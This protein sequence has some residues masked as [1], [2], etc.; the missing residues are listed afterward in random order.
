MGKLHQLLAVHD[1][2]QTTFKK[3]VEEGISTFTKKDNLFQGLTSETVSKLEE[4]D[5]RY[6][7]FPSSTETVPVAETVVSKLEYI[8]THACKF[9]DASY[10]IDTANTKAVADVVMEDGKV[11]AK[12]LPAVTILFLENKFKTIRGLIEAVPT[13]DPAKVWTPRNDMPGVYANPPVSVPVM[14]LVKEHIVIV[15]ATDKHPAQVGIKESRVPRAVKTTTTLSGRISTLE[16]SH[17]L[18][19]CDALINALKKAR[20]TANDIDHSN[21]NISES[22]V[23]YLFG[24]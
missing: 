15:N 24:K 17:L 18:A 16:K 10:Q 9:F 4:T 14:E 7:E 2:L 6:S 20:Q 22:F 5:P 13:L 11:I 8:L 19:R 3:V 21:A 12:S 1:S 23:N